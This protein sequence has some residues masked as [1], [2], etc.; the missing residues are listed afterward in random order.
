MDVYVARQPIYDTRLNVSAY[1]LLFRSSL[2]D[3]FS[4]SDS[5]YASLA[6]LVNSF[7]AI[8]IDRLSNGRPVHV[9][10]T[11]QLLQDGIPSLF[12]PD[13]VVVEVLENTMPS[14]A[15][16]DALARLKEQGFSIALD[17]YIGQPHL[18]PFLNLVDIVK[19]DFLLASHAQRAAIPRSAVKP[20]TVFLA[21][22]VATRDE[23]Q[24]AV[25]HGYRLFQ[26]NFLSRPEI[27]KGSD[28]PPDALASLHLLRQVHDPSPDFDTLAS[29]ISR[30]VSLSYRLL[31]VVN[32]AAFGLRHRVTSIK[33]ALVIMGLSEIRRW[34]AVLTVTGLS[35]EKPRALAEAAIVRARMTELLATPAGLAHR[36]S[37]LFLTGLLSLMDALLDRPMSEVVDLLPLT[38]DTR[39]ALLGEA[40]PFLPVLQMV[41]A[42]E[43]AQWEQVEATAPTLG[44]H[45][46]FLPEAYADSLAWADELGRL[47]KCYAC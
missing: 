40:G 45:Q 6:L 7:I 19:V 27:A 3:V 47:E 20:N 24:T 4:C 13:V 29:I 33:H 2:N 42:Y 10:F 15:V 23:F 22:K 44:I 12:P 39:T 31:R 34:I 5:D 41:T 43:N 32:S 26:G 28:I 1:E 9:N 25:R 37:E 11:Q 38:E 18:E 46:A 14:P 21:E 35:G 16:L 8:G 17:D 30:D 36:A